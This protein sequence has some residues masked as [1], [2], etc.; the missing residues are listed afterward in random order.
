MLKCLNSRERNKEFH[1]V[2]EHETLMLANSNEIVNGRNVDG[3]I[4]Y[5][6]K[7]FK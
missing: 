4:V 2:I 3:G 7:M 1:Q 5:A 6:K